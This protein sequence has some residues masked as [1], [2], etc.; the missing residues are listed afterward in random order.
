M[1]SIS[2]SKKGIAVQDLTEVIAAMIIIFAIFG[3]FQGISRVAQKNIDEKTSEK[4]VYSESADLVLMLLQ[5]DSGNKNMDVADLI[6]NSYL[7]DDY[8]DLEGVVK[9]FFNKE[10]DKNWL[11]IIEIVDKDSDEERLVEIEPPATGRVKVTLFS[12]Q[13][14]PLPEISE[15]DDYN[16]ITVKLFYVNR[17]PKAFV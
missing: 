12:S 4:F 1:S 17:A 15:F 16:F 10:F 11:A 7:E 9:D 2:R 8:D 13:N 5:N 3:I 6:I 14:I